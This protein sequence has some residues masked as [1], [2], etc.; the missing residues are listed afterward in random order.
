MNAWLFM[1]FTEIE[2]GSVYVNNDRRDH[3]RPCDI[4]A[5]HLQHVQRL[6]C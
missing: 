6:H 1:G 4:H 5:D 3:H 2:K